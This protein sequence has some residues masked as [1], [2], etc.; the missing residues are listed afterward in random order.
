MTL[1][2]VARIVVSIGLLLAWAMPP[3][4]ATVA[5]ATGVGQDA[6]H[7]VSGTHCGDTFPYLDHPSGQ[8]VAQNNPGTYTPAQ[9]SSHNQQVMVAEP[10]GRHLHE[11]F[12]RLRDGHRQVFD[13]QFRGPAGTF[14]H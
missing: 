5:A 12:P 9:H 13:H 2:H 11:S 7:L 3:L 10:A 1:K 6:D 4:T 14:Q 8:L